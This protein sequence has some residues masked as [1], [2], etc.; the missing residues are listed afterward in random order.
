MILDLLKQYVILIVIAIC[1]Y[2]VMKAI[3]GRDD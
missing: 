3:S 2:L 1:W